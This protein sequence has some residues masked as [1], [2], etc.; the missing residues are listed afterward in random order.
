MWYKF[1]G[2]SERLKIA[3]YLRPCLWTVM[4]VCE[5][6]HYLGPAEKA[7]K[8]CGER[9]LEFSGV[10]RK[11]SNSYNIIKELTKWIDKKCLCMSNI[12]QGSPTHQ[13]CGVLHTSWQ[14]QTYPWALHAHQSPWVGP[15]CVQRRPQEGRASYSLWCSTWGRPETSGPPT[16]WFPSGQRWRPLPLGTSPGV[17]GT[18]PGCTMSK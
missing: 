4:M 12:H 11:G 1:K 18:W 5:T 9:S 13:G 8:A 14:Q 3:Y 17:L 10:N 2:D 15:V 16:Q 7:T 6:I